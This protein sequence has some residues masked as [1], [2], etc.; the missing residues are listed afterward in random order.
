[1]PTPL[2]KP[3]V[4]GG[5]GWWWGW[6][7][8]NAI[9]FHAKMC[10]HPPPPPPPPFP[11]PL[12][13]TPLH[14]HHQ[15]SLPISISSPCTHRG[16]LLPPNGSQRPCLP[17]SL[18]WAATSSSCHVPLLESSTPN[19]R[20]GSAIPPSPS[21]ARATS[22]HCRP[23]SALLSIVRVKSDI[24]SNTAPHPPLRP[25]T[26]CLAWP[27]LPGGGAASSESFL[28]STT[29]TLTTSLEY[30]NGQW[31]YSQVLTF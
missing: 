16:F 27:L 14:H 10:H 23:P 1:V 26:V 2:A 25:P 13:H 17:P 15:A 9:Q 21:H 19:A 28:K 18:M 4:L 31:T 12:F 22:T 11:L 3:P 29:T 6:G 20:S 5:G 30:Q 7:V 24:L 8:N